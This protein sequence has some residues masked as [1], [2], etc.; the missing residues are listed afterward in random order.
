[1]ISS[2]VPCQVKVFWVWNITGSKHGASHLFGFPDWYF[3]SFSFGIFISLSLF[4]LWI[5]ITLSWVLSDFFCFVLCRDVRMDTKFYLNNFSHS[6]KKK[7]KAYLH[8]RLYCEVLVHWTVIISKQVILHG[9]IHGSIQLH[10]YTAHVVLWASGC[11][12]V[13]SFIAEETSLTLVFPFFPPRYPRMLIN[14]N[15][16]SK[17][18]WWR[19]KHLM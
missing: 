12:N 18:I 3:L 17:Q 14:R 10:E 11:N 8:W 9:I 7:K 2:V 6:I 13:I 4:F 16:S 1:M 19:E 15:R 5:H